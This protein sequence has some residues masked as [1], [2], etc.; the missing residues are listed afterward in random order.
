MNRVAIS[1]IFGF[2]F[3]P[4]CDWD[5]II[6]IPGTII[7]IVTNSL[8]SML[9]QNFVFHNEYQ[10]NFHCGNDIAISSGQMKKPFKHIYSTWPYCDR[11][12]AWIDIPPR[13]SSVHVE[14]NIPILA[15]I[16][17]SPFSKIFRN[18][19]FSC[20]GSS[21]PDLGRWVSATLEF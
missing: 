13:C 17:L 10:H 2:S 1:K 3:L 8:K 20:P 6:M 11:M 21:I 5:H 14:P 7:I 15:L 12:Q 9:Y 16:F 19:I 18:T 4:L